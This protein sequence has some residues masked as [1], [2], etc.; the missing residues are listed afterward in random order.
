MKS[1]TQARAARRAGRAEPNAP[2][3]LVSA[4]AEVVGSALVLDA[5]L[6]VV[7]ATA[8]AEHLLGLSIPLGIAAPKLLCG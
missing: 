2:S 6:R 8:E 3:V 7:A 1:S 4:L 5:E